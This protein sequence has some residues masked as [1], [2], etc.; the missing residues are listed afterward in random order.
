M[1]RQ[2]AIL[3]AVGL[4]NLYRQASG[5]LGLVLV[6]SRL[7]PIRPLRFLNPFHCLQIQTA[8]FSPVP[9]HYSSIF[10]PWS[11]SL[12]LRVSFCS[13]GAEPCQWG[14]VRNETSRGKRAVT[15]L[16]DGKFAR[17]RR[18]VDVVCI[19][20][21]AASACLRLFRTPPPPLSQSTLRFHLQSLLSSSLIRRACAVR[22]VDTGIKSLTGAR[23]SAQ[24]SF[25]SNTIR[26]PGRCA[27]PQ[28]RLCEAD[29]SYWPLRATLRGRRR[30]SH[31]LLSA[32]GEPGKLRKC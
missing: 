29:K 12:A 27:D 17:S 28:T 31:L 14:A 7:S 8:L 16:Y 18:V 6:Y 15:A 11:N 26:Q 13:I 24:E 23:E 5:S 9:H 2:V 30:H 32:A 4:Y 1:C 22:C 19:Y 10:L 25:P 3:V 21:H 20:A